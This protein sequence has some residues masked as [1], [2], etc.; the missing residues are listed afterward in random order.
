[1]TSFWIDTDHA[2]STALAW[3]RRGDELASTQLNVELDLDRLQLG[4][5]RSTVVQRLATCSA[6]LWVPAAFVQLLVVHVQ[7]ADAGFPTAPLDGATILRLRDE[8]G[9]RVRISITDACPAP[10]A[11]PAFSSSSGDLGG[12]F[13]SELRSPFFTVGATPDARGRSL[14]ARALADSASTAQIRADEF[15]LIELANGA[16]LIV[17]PGV[18]DLSTPD[19]G[20]SERNR[21][22]RDLDQHAYP[23]S[24]STEVDDNRYAA[25]VQQALANAGVPSGADLMIVGHSFGADTA[26][27]LA[28][29]D[30]FNGPDGYHVTH[31]VAAG[32]Y[33]DPQL[34]HVDPRTNVLVLQNHRDA[35]VIVEAVAHGN[36]TDAIDSA[37]SMWD[38]ARDFDVV[39]AASGAAATAYHGAGAF[40]DGVR[41][42]IDH[43]DD[44]ADIG[45]GVATFDRGRI[46]DG[47][48]R[49]VTLDPGIRQPVDSQIVDVFEGGAGGVGHHPDNYVDHVYDVDDVRLA[50]FFASIDLAGYTTVGTSW[51]IDISVP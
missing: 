41:Y 39:G 30:R 10:W 29:D 1:M 37:A 12:T 47:A 4:S 33:S 31:V 14:V 42:G 51:A 46:T 8:A 45:V 7:A 26:L 19:I 44:L 23:S 25:L 2:T 40:V 16:F 50:E 27:D 34:A 5:V 32:Y 22:P 35:A 11:V 24:Q 18:T 15:E 17:L 13:G 48:S 6:E 21:S 36:V 43:R 9:Y 38:R 20:L 3:A 28:A 49:F